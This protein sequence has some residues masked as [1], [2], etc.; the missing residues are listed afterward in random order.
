MDAFER[1]SVRI[2]IWLIIS[3]A[4]VAV[5]VAVGIWLFSLTDEKWVSIVG[6]V[7]GGLILYPLGMITQVQLFSALEKYRGMGI[8]GLLDNRHDKPYYRPIVASAKAIVKVTGASATRFIDDFLN[9]DD[10]DRVLVDA[11]RHHTT[12]QVRILVPAD[13][14][15]S[16][17]ARS[18]WTAKSAIVT[19]LEKEFGRRFQVKRFDEEARHSFIVVDEDFVGGPV[20]DGDKS[21]HAPAVHVDA[22]T[23][24]GRK[25]LAYFDDLWQRS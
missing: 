3:V 16:E 4:V 25:Y 13:Q 6:G 21:R 22:R 9:P 23:A 24:F 8:K 14:H 20:F 10:D 2:P 11:L 17:D 12:L 19:R 5:T 7:F 1:Q 18:R 15:M